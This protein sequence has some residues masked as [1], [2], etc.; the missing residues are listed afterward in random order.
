MT[1]DELKQLANLARIDLSE[2]ELE[3]VAQEFDAIL[4]YVQQMDQATIGQVSEQSLQVNHAR[5]DTTSHEENRFV[6]DL[7]ANAPDTQDG[8]YKVPKIL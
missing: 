1:H 7:L 8:F 3:S 2:T 5:S 4:G 6:D